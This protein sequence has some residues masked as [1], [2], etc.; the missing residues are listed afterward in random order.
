MFSRTA[1]PE[2]NP[3]PKIKATDPAKTST[4]ISRASHCETSSQ[5]KD[6]KGCAIAEAKQSHPPQRTDRIALS[7]MLT[8][9]K[10][11]SETGTLFAVLIGSAFIA[12]FTR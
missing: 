3:T 1:Y 11:K 7:A 5:A 2:A 12:Y 10:R 9:V 4:S 6:S 8:L